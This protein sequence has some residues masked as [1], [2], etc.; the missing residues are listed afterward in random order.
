LD[1]AILDLTGTF[2]FYPLPTL[3]D[4]GKRRVDY[5][6][7]VVLRLND[8]EREPIRQARENALENY[9]ARLF[10]YVAKK[11]ANANQFVL[12][13]IIGGIKKEAHPTIW[14]E[15]QRYYILGKLGAV[16]TEL[17]KL[18]DDAPEALTW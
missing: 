9:S 12:D 10:K 3:N 16:D 15:M 4:K 17:K 18:F 7:N 8:G 14:K 5:T 1:F 2:K 6:Y 13:K 11:K